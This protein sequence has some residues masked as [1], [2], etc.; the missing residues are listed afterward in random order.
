MLLTT[1]STLKAQ[2]FLFSK[3]KLAIEI[4]Y[5]LPSVINPSK[6]L[7]NLLILMI[8]ECLI[9]FQRIRFM[10][11]VIILIVGVFYIRVV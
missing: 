3:F 6:A 1:K 9:P 5:H 8:I 4:S 2:H 10:N 7:T 11:R